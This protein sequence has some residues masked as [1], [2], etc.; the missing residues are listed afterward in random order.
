MSSTAS[1]KNYHYKDIISPMMSVWIAGKAIMP[2]KAKF[3]SGK[4]VLTL[5][6]PGD[7]EAN[8]LVQQKESHLVL[9]LLYLSKETV[10]DLIGEQAEEIAYWF[11]ILNAPRAQEILKFEEPLRG[12]LLNLDVA[13]SQGRMMSWE[14]AYG[15]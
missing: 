15:V 11:C 4:N 8:I 2:R 7:I 5:A 10:I 3:D 6:Y 13:N 1:E 12:H 14:E 9:E